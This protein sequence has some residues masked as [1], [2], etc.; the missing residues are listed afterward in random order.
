MHFQMKGIYVPV[1]DRNIEDE[2]IPKAI[3]E[4]R[5]IDAVRSL[6]TP[7]VLEIRH[8]DCC[9]RPCIHNTG[10]CTVKHA[11]DWQVVLA[12]Q[13]NENLK[14]KI[15]LPW[16]ITN[17]PEPQ[18]ELVMESIMENPDMMENQVV[19]ENQDVTEN[20]DVMEND[21]VMENIKEPILEDFSDSESYYSSSSEDDSLSEGELDSDINVI[22]IDSDVEDKSNGNKLYFKGVKRKLTW[23]LSET[24]N[25]EEQVGRQSKTNC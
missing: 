6:G 10:N 22:E 25:R 12:R 21:A 14:K 3:P 9:C 13:S 8:F 16:V 2:G 15:D 23:S 19:M 11:D 18:K 24:K 1:V 7:G 20:E 5:S 17:E 4:T